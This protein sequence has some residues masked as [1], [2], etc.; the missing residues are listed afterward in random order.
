MEGEVRSKT[1]QN[2]L[3]TRFS[4]TEAQKA[5][6]MA[7]SFFNP[8][9]NGK[10]ARLISAVVVIWG[11]DDDGE[12]LV[13]Q[14]VHLRLYIHDVRVYAASEA[15]HIGMGMNEIFYREIWRPIEVGH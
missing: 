3:K 12:A 14:T 7:L 1:G 8:A 15:I 10:H 9:G 11:G 2:Q 5:V 4:L 6:K 13:R